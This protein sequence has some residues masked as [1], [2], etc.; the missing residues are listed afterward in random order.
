MKFTAHEYGPGD[1]VLYFWNGCP[2]M[3]EDVP[4]RFATREDATKYAKVC[5]GSDSEVEVVERKGV[6]D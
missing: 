3:V 1:W 2:V 6:R 5:W 4:L